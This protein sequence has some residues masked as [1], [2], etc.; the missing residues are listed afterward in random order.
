[1]GKDI[2]PSGGIKKEPVSVNT[3]SME[4]IGDKNGRHEQGRHLDHMGEPNTF[5]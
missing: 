3:A 4:A 2:Y 5:W 1:M